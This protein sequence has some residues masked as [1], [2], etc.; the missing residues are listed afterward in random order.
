MKQT[1]PLL[2]ITSFLAVILIVNISSAENIYVAQTSQGTGDGS[3]AANAHDLAW[4][5][6]AANW[7]SGAG[8]IGPGDTVHLCGTFAIAL[9]GSGLVVHGS[10]T[11][12][13][14]ITIRFEPGAVFQSP[15]FNNDP[16][17][18]GGA[19]FSSGNSW[20]VID[21]GTTAQGSPS[22]IIEN[23]DNGTTLNNHQWSLGLAMYNCDNCEV[24]NLIIRNVYVHTST[25]DEN[26][27]DGNNGLVVSGS[28]WRVDHNVFHDIRWALSHGYNAGDTNNEID[29]NEFY[30]ID[31]GFTLA[32]ATTGTAKNDYFHDNYVHDYSNWDTQNNMFHHDGIHSWNSA[33]L[34]GGTKWG[35]F[36]GL[37]VYN[38]RFDGDCGGNFNEHIFLEGGYDNTGRTPWTQLFSTPNAFI[39]GNLFR[40]TDNPPRT[41]ILFGVTGPAVIFNNTMIGNDPEAGA[42]VFWFGGAGLGGVSGLPQVNSSGLD[43]RNNLSS[44]ENTLIG[45]SAS[46]TWTHLPDHEF[47]GYYTNSYNAFWGFGV[48]VSNFTTWKSACNCD[49]NSMADPGPLTIVDANGVPVSGSWLVGHGQNMF[50][51]G[52]ALPG[53]GVDINGKARPAAGQGNWDV[54]AYQYT[55]AGIKGAFT[56][57][58]NR[59]HFAWAMLPNPVKVAQ[60]SRFLRNNGNAAVYDLSGRRMDVNTLFQP[61]VYL[62]KEIGVTA[63][64]RVIV[65]R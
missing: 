16:G 17:F 63:F 46:D 59:R 42:S 24:K 62:L 43:I 38:N 58:A 6:A 12:G 33:L 45:G 22:G 40:C 21:G 4:I 52:Y 64:Q 8:K 7:G 34:S 36:T 9:N 15:A 23:T 48:D 27:M 13:S 32:S 2:F 57:G 61:G 30:N 41:H 26:D 55:A 60:L 18:A 44:G 39:Y 65:V 10:G 47:Y 29:H 31:H 49:A 50:D 3:S 28:N 53:M 35:S 20:L 14:P 56:P 19:I 5:N 11:A 37:Y 51:A 25:S 1:L 54:G